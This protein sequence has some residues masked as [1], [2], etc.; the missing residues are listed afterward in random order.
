[1]Q[2]LFDFPRIWLV[3]GEIILVWEGWHAE[4]V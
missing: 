1:M 3:F 4:I 2:K